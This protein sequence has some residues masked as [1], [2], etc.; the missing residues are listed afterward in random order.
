MFFLAQNP[1]GGRFHSQQQRGGSNF[2]GWGEGVRE[3]GGKGETG[4]RV[5]FKAKTTDRKFLFFKL[6]NVIVL[7]CCGASKYL[8]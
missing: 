7:N 3:G 6:Q 5:F 8:E 2:L 1:K 4:E